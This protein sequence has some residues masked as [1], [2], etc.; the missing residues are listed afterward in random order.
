MTMKSNWWAFTAFNDDIKIA[1]D[2]KNYPPWIVNV[3]GGL[4]RCKPT[5]DCPEGRLHFQ[6]AIQCQKNT[7]QRG[8]A[9]KKFLPTAK[10]W[11]VSNTFATVHYVMK[12]ATAVGDK[13]A[14]ANPNYYPQWQIEDLFILLAEN[15][16]FTKYEVGRKNAMENIFWDA[17]CKVSLIDKRLTS[18]LQNPSNKNYWCRTYSVWQK[19]AKESNNARTNLLVLRSRTSDAT[20]AT[21]SAVVAERVA[22]PSD[23]EESPWD[24]GSCEKDEC[25]LCNFKLLACKGC[26]VG[27]GFVSEN[28]KVCHEN[29][30]V[31]HP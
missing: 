10:I 26:G 17:V 11:K 15:A 3:Y 5:E 29:E 13:E 23:S 31:D 1:M 6:G 28:C 21:K 9:V 19:F 25:E 7:Q 4:E 20:T 24:C 14:I 18:Q 16:D 8:S 27:Y 2:K 12:Y 30:V 22:T